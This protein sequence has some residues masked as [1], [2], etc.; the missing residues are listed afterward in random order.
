MPFELLIPIK[1]EPW[2]P[3]LDDQRG[4]HA[5]LMQA[6]AHSN[7]AL[8]EQIHAAH[9][10]PFTQWLQQSQEDTADMLW[11]VALLDDALYEPLVAGLHATEPNSV[12]RKPIQ[13]DLSSIY[14]DHCTYDALAAEP[15]SFKHN[16]HFKSPTSF[17]KQYYHSPIPEPYLCWQSWWAHWQAFAPPRLVINIAVLDVVAAHLVISWFRLGSQVARGNQWQFIGAVGNMT[18]STIQTDVL[19]AQWWQ[20]VT[21]LAAFSRFCGTGHKTAFGMGQTAWRSADGNA[22][23]S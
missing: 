18:F 19:E 23:T 10:N 14:S 20:S 17:K 12:A 11:R 21:T 15:V 9:I 4:M 3:D 6:L 1:G 7:T 2:I 5:I 8:A 22:T 13:I 16:L